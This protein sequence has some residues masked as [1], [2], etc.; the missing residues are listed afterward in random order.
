MNS[1]IHPIDIAGIVF[2]VLVVGCSQR[3]TIDIDKVATSIVLEG[4]PDWIEIEENSVWISNGGL[5]A[6]QRIDP[7]TNT[8]VTDVKVNEPCAAITIGFGSVWVMSCGDKTLLRIDLTNNKIVA[9]I[10]MTIANDEGSI[11]AA[12]NG[13]WILTDR[14]GILTRIDPMTNAVVSNIQV[15]PNSFAAMAGFGSIWVTNTGENES[16]DVGSVQRI[17]P[18]TN[19]VIS[20]ISV[21]KQPRF[22]AVGE[23]AVWTFNQLEGSVTRIDPQ[24]NKVVATIECNVPGTGG[25]ISAGEG[26]VWVRAKTEL[27][28]KINPLTNQI[29]SIFGP[30]AGSGAVRAGSGAIWISAHDINKVWRMDSPK[31]R[32]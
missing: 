30:Q 16:T 11:V 14:R 19:Q 24:T 20:T 12:E 13:V 21:G 31:P 7:N 15:K 5:N 26:Y 25:D 9:S 28:I 32:N 6:V 18:A 22:L 29:E 4:Y 17:D 3:H 1:K 27:L 10:P 8:V 2:L 23:G